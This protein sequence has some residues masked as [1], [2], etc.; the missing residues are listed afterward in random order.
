MILDYPRRGSVATFAFIAAALV[1]TPLYAQAPAAVSTREVDDILAKYNEPGM[2]GCAIGVVQNDVLVLSRGYGLADVENNVPINAD[3]RFDIGSMSKQFLAMAVLMLASEGKIDLDADVHAYVSELPRYES[4]ISLRNLLHHTS[5]LKDYDQLQRIAG[6]RDG[7]VQSFSDVLWIIERQKSLAFEPGS[8]YSYSDS[9]Y[10]LLGIIA[11]RVTGKPVDKLLEEMIFRPLGMNNTSLR[12]NHWALVPHK[13][14]P[15]RIEDGKP[16]LFLNGE[17][18]LGDGGV[19]STIADLAKWERNFDDGKVGGMRILQEMQ[20]AEPLADG[21]PNEYAAGLY[22]RRYGKLRMIEH[23][24]ASYGFLAEK[25]RFPEEHLSVMALCNRRDGPYVEISNSLADLYL[26]LSSKAEETAPTEIQ[27]KAQLERLAGL[28]FSDAA[29]DGILLEARDGALYDAGSDREFRQT[30]PLAFKSAPSGTLCRCSATYTF[31]LRPN[32]SVEGFVAARPSGSIENGNITDQYSRMQPANYNLLPQLA[33]EY[34][35]DD[36]ATS[37][38][39]LRNGNSLSVRRRGFAD[40]SMQLVWS[41]AV[42]GPN[43]VLQFNRKN[44][45]VTGFSLRNIRLNAVEFRRLPPGQH[46]VPQPWVCQ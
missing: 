6:W 16:Q 34:V 2:P 35:S 9:N 45:R 26:R 36:V 24:G 40:R 33:G 43:G 3:T 7:D 19:F 15:Y 41:D 21:T 44:G 12:T 4:K 28:Y 31:Q 10:F 27:T 13:A 8:R 5:G 18:P 23:S 39:I 32:G 29:A 30:G 20:Q 14:W 17:E 38:C 1:F 22:V 46:P 25:I 37:W 42:D 11:Q